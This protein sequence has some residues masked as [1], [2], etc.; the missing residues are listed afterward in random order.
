MTPDCV[1]ALVWEGVTYEAADVAEP[2][3]L[4]K[5]LGKALIPIVRCEPKRKVNI[6]EIEG[7]H[8]SIA[9]VAPGPEGAHPD[10]DLVW[11]GPGYLAPSPLHPLHEELRVALGDWENA[12]AGYRCQG[13]R[14]LPAQAK[15]RPA[16]S[17][18]FVRVSSDDP[19]FGAFLE[20]EDVDG[21]V[22]LDANTVVMGFRRHGVPFIDT[23]DEFELTVR[24]CEGKESVPGMAGLQ[25]LVVKQLRPSEPG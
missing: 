12:E 22:N 11:L 8:P 15:E 16:A 14:V 5:R 2:P 13:P 7:I 20:R 17:Q 4:G 3:P 25:R 19:T 9:L 18:G 23:G 6:S 10:S 1:G 24:K 21:I